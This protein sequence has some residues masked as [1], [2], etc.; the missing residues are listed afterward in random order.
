MNRVQYRSS[1]ETVEFLSA[2]P[3]ALKFVDLVCVLCKL[4]SLTLLICAINVIQVVVVGWLIWVLLVF[5]L[6][7]YC[8]QSTSVIMLF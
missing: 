6:S 5:F 2:H 8:S 3:C 4:F 1:L 7:G